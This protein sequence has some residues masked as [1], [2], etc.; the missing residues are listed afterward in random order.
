MLM[1]A[2]PP[3]RPLLIF[4]GDCSFCR[5]WIARWKYL[6]EGKIDY[7][8]YQS[9]AERAPNVPREN[10]GKSVYLLEPDGTST[11]A[12]KAVFRALALGGRMRLLLW[13]YEHASPFRWVSETL[14][15]FV[16]ANRN[17][18]DKLDRI[19]VGT[20]TRPATYVLTRALFLRLLGV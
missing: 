19:V 14:Y 16:A 9:A 15:K 8:P 18:L 5:R 1:S 13:L 12:A 10:C 4:D 6:T 2:P 17:P 11:R 7:E 20:E 3:T